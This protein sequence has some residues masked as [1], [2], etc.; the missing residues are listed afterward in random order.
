M[1]LDVKVCVPFPGANASIPAG[2]TEETGLSSRYVQGAA[3]GADTDLSTDRGAAT[4]THT[5]AGH[6]PIQ[7]SHNHNF[8]TN[9]LSDLITTASTGT[10]GASGTHVHGNANSASATATNQSA[11]ATI[12]NANNGLAYREVIWIKASGGTA[13]GIPNNAYAFLNSDSLPTN[14]NRYDNGKYLL[15][16][17]AGNNGGATAGSNTHTH[18][19]TGTHT[20]TQDAHNHA[21]TNSASNTTG[22]G[23]AGVSTS[24]A[25]K[26]HYHIV[27]FANETAVNQAGT[28]TVASDSSEPQYRLLNII[29][30]ETG[31]QD[32]PDGLIA[33]FLGTHAQA[34][35]LT[36]WARFTDMDGLFLK[37]AANGEIPATGGAQTH[38][39]SGTTCQPTQ[40]AHAHTPTSGTNSGSAVRRATG[41]SQVA[42]HGH[43][44]LTIYPA[45]GFVVDNKTA[46][47]KSLSF[48]LNAN[49]S[50]TH[51]PPY[52]R[53]I[54]I[55][56]TAPAITG[57][58]Q[59]TLVG[60]GA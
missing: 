27:S 7:N 56:Y 34:G 14:W 30:N 28:V 6:T 19:E 25:P 35:A 59:R 1:A 32:L 47:N 54:F 26:T 12:G 43:Y 16:V 50:E 37:G 45:E 36:D 29:K 57:S 52:R 48:A 15:G 2:W 18:T 58:P 22:A 4:H 40:N 41:S 51:Y 42:I 24:I 60:V 55:Q 31:G 23:S 11:T 21:N 44:H 3:A 17:G 9:E 39:H 8:Y 46:T 10:S 20:H 33:L 49:T 53:V 38:T 13:T 5:D